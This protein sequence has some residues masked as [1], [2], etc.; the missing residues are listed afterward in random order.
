MAG[1]P[2][3]ERSSELWQKLSQR[4]RP[5]TTVPFPV[6][7]GEV[8]P[9]EL[10]LWVLTDSELMQARANADVAA[11]KVLLGDVKDGDLGYRDIYNSELAVQIL[12]LAARD[13]RDLELRTFISPKHLRDKLT[14]DEIAQ[15]M[16]QYSEFRRDRGPF[17]TEL[18]EAECEAWLVVLREGAKRD[19]LALL[20]GEARNDLILYL[21][22]L[23]R[24]SPTGTTSAGSP[25]G[26]S[27]PPGSD[28]VAVVTVD[29]SEIATPA[30]L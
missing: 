30:E 19:P 13:P 20:S 15:L 28:V 10:S 11:K 25:P 14:T 16:I 4:P 17:L 24:G 5:T 27:T 3:P 22:S 8:S 21:V 2:N 7:K 26:G 12:C 6:P 18:S 23:L 9:G 29:A 1:A